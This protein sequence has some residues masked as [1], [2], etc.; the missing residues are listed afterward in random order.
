MVIETEV[1]N[2]SSLALYESLD[3]FREKRL[4]RFYTNGKDASVDDSFYQMLHKADDQI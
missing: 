2:Q 1:D 3:F 4:H